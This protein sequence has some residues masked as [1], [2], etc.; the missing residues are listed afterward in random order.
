MLCFVGALMLVVQ[1]WGQEKGLEAVRIMLERMA[2]ELAD[3]GNE[4]VAEEVV[5]HFEKLLLNPL[6]INRANREDLQMLGILTDFQVESLLE[7]RNGSGN[8]LST[9]E[10]QL[11]NG[12]HKEIV[13]ILEPFITFGTPENRGTGSRKHNSTLLFKWWHKEGEKGYIGPPFYSQIKYAVEFAEKFCGGITLEK[14][15]GEKIIGKGI[16][17]IGDFFSFHVG[18]QGIQL[19]KHTSVRNIVLGDYTIRLGQGLAVWNAFRLNGDIQVQGAYRKGN[20]MAPYT[21]SDE[22]RFFRG[23]AVS[24]NR[25]LGRFLDLETLL[26][27][28]LKN[29]DARVSGNKYTSLPSDGLHN[30]ES[31][32]E[33]RKR[34]G[35]TAYGGSI[36]LRSEKSKVGL[37]YI[38]YGY[39]AHNGRRVQEYN[40]YQM[41]DGQHGNFSIDF[42]SVLGKART[43]AE[44]AINYGGSFA[45]VCGVIFRIAGW[46]SAL[47]YRN[48]SKSYIAPYAGALSTTGSCS[49]QEGITLSFEKLAGNTRF[50]GGGTLTHYPYIRYGTEGPSTDCKIWC[51]G[52]SSF[53]NG[54]W[55]LKFQCRNTQEKDAEI[56]TGSTILGIKGSLKIVL[57]N[58]IWLKLKGEYS[59]EGFRSAGFAAALDS[60][61]KIW[62]ES[63]RLILHG[64]YYNCPNW[65]NRIYMYEYDL[66]SSYVSRLMYGKGFQWYALLQCRIWKN[67]ALHLKADDEP[68]VKL[69]VKM[70]FF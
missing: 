32:L 56:K 4:A 50:T 31:L 21:S 30:T 2:E 25:N 16:L 38:G 54:S 62:K 66:P 28:S 33:T 12:F 46:E 23:G 55:D 65:Y 57:K 40:R 9:T 34:L 3:E 22:N 53:R 13:E 7:Y 35:E 44:A 1:V 20:A 41:Y 11:V 69:G 45:V 27:F 67:V 48:Y 49:N 19:G 42:S 6:D 24:F 10:L 26:F 59:T 29:V 51:K 63:I 58:W 47:T 68:K 43:F 8:I 37:N 61:L 39:N 14:D 15:S 18:A 70:M 60:E 5:S 17:P 36:M 52:E 64:A